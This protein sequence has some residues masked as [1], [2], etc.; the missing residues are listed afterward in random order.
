MTSNEE[1]EKWFYT[2][3]ECDNRFGNKTENRHPYYYS[4]EAWDHQQKKV[5]KANEL[6]KEAVEMLDNY[7]GEHFSYKIEPFLN[8]PEVKALGEK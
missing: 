2:S 5:D 1:F 4:K 7:G 6:L 3:D 8:K